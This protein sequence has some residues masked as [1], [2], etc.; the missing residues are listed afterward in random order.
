MMLIRIRRKYLKFVEAERIK[1][2]LE[3]FFVVVWCLTLFGR[4]IKELDAFN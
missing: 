1:S 4:D 2:V 3:K